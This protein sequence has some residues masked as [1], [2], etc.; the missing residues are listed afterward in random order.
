MSDSLSMLWLRIGNLFPVVRIDRPLDVHC[1]T[2]RQLLSSRIHQPGSIFIRH[3]GEEGSSRK[4][5]IETG[6]ENAS[7]LLCRSEG[8]SSFRHLPC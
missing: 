3:P 5:R 6:S 8:L 7:G 4:D 2:L 1:P